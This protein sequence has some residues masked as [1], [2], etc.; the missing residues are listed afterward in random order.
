MEMLK[1]IKMRNKKWGL[2]MIIT[3]MLWKP[4]SS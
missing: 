1:M 4:S 3:K 2:R